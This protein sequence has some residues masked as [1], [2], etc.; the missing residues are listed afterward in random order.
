MVAP[1]NTSSQRPYNACDNVQNIWLLLKKKSL[2][3][4]Q[5]TEFKKPGSGIRVWIN[6]DLRLVAH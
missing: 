3:K 6:D 4:F 1:I 2:Q 5:L